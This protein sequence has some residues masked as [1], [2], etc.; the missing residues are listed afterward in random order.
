[1]SVELNDLCYR[2]RKLPALNN[3]TS[4]EN[5]LITVQNLR[6]NDPERYNKIGGDRGVMTI[7][8][9]AIVMSD[10]GCTTCGD[11]ILKWAGELRLI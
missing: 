5:F 11:K 9:N 2:C 6:S 10:D 3:G 8:N 7:L 1:M 4:V